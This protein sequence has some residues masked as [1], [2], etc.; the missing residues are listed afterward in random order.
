MLV[1]MERY[2]HRH[3][4]VPH[5]PPQDLFGDLFHHMAQEIWNAPEPAQNNSQVKLCDYS[6]EDPNCS[7]SLQVWQMYPPDHMFYFGIHNTNCQ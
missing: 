7:D 2:V 3:D 1:R 6:G 5:A 4:D